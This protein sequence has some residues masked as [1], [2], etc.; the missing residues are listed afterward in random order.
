MRVYRHGHVNGLLTGNTLS[1]AQ[2]KLRGAGIDT[3]LIAWDQSFFAADAGLPFIAVAT[4]VFSSAELQ[5]AGAVAVIDDLVTGSERLDQALRVLAGSP[6][7]MPGASVPSENR[8]A[9]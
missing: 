6:E 4:G 2:S 9:R 7:Q 1:R 3:G 5:D 8:R